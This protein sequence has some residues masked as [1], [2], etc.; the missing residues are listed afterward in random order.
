MH[1]KLKERIIP[2][3]PEMKNGEPVVK[4]Y[5]LEIKKSMKRE[6]NIFARL[7]EKPLNSRAKTNFELLLKRHDIAQKR[8]AAYLNVSSSTIS[9]WAQG[10]TTIPKEKKFNIKKFFE[11]LHRIKK[12]SKKHD[13][14]I[15]F[16]VGN[17]RNLSNWKIYIQYLIEP[18]HDDWKK[19]L[20]VL[21][22]IGVP[23]PETPSLIAVH[24]S[25]Y[26]TNI[27]AA[28]LYSQLNKAGVENI[29]R[30]MDVTPKKPLLNPRQH[31]PFDSLV[32]ELMISLNILDRWCNTF[33][34][35]TKED[36]LTNTSQKIKNRLL[37]VAFLSKKVVRLVEK[38]GTNTE[39]L[40]EKNIEIRS[41]VN[42]L[43]GHLCKEL[44]EKGKSISTD[45]FEFVKLKPSQLNE[46]I[47][48]HKTKSEPHI[49][50]YLRYG[51]RE[52]VQMIKILTKTQNEI[53]ER[54]KH[55]EQLLKQL[56]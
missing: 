47:E 37:D 46:Q 30:A 45:Y 51:E 14:N 20:L 24:L 49:N 56:L 9:A 42:N 23:I 43:I 52:I 5:E 41:E 38:T 7:D 29:D 11:H 53:I 12:L 4:L 54:I 32:I 18:L 35:K 34:P 28:K 40:E 16:L 48:Q 22:D 13:E 36:E 17:P 25:Q 39:K 10:T 6:G 50:D 26:P 33:L 1:S 15:M 8:I 2:V 55:N 3:S 21:N 19:L 44:L 31:K 27:K